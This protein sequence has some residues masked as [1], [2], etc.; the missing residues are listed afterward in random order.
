[1]VTRA[2]TTLPLESVTLGYMKTQTTDL[3]PFDFASFATGVLAERDRVARDLHDTLLQ[4]LSGLRMQIAALSKVATSDLC[5]ER[6]VMVQ[7]QADECL[8]E[9]REAV[10]DI[11][12]AKSESL[13]LVAALKESGQRLNAEPA[14]RF[15]FAVEGHPRPIPVDLGEQLLRIGREAITNASKHSCAEQIRVRLRYGTDSIRLQIC[16]DGH[17]FNPERVS[18]APGHYGLTTMRERAEQI[19]ASISIF[20]DLARGTSVQVTVPHAA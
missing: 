8:R 9:A 6:L 11:R 16:D 17:G 1:M 18:S 14:S 15:D 10:W 13:D 7:A 12:E 19:D 4:S 5:N 3:P 2:T 20:S